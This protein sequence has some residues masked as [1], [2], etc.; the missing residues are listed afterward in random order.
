[1]TLFAGNDRATLRATW[2]EAWRRHRDGLPLAPLQAQLADIVAMHP[3]YQALFEDEAA[4][5]GG[6]RMPAQGASNP[7]LHLG[8]HAAVR[9]AVATDRPP[10]L[11][12]AFE[13]LLQRAATPHDAEHV[14]AECLGETL[15]EAQRAAQPPDGE[16][17]LE[18]VR[19]RSTA[20]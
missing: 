12:R 19:R 6:E 9:E 8:L 13:A 20:R 2:R 17:W 3:E 1:M 5:E 11:R 16:A 10:G 14:L 18:R 15:W 7:F 4:A